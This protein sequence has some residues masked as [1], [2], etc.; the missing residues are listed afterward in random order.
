MMLAHHRGNPP[1]ELAEQI[2]E[3]A[4]A[5]TVRLGLPIF[6]TQHHQAHARA[7]EL[8]RQRSPIRLA[9]S[10][11]ARLRAAPREQSLFEN[12]V[13]QLGRH[14]PSNSARLP[15]ADCPGSCCAPP[16]ACGRSRARS[17]RHGAAATCIVTVAWSALSS[18]A[19]PTSSLMRK[20]WLPE[21][22]TR[23]V[24][25]RPFAPLS[26]GW[27]ASPRNGGRLQFGTVAGIKSESRPAS[28]RN[29]WPECVGICNFPNLRQNGAENTSQK[30]TPSTN[31]K[32]RG[33][34]ATLRWR[35]PDAGLG[36]GGP[37]RL[38]RRD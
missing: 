22:L 15:A 36:A 11:Q 35:L 30:T 2:A 10:A 8:A 37:A 14:R 26:R 3:P 5:V 31:D 20:G 33:K 38:Y 13:G 16:P 23:R 27:P 9:A 21:S 4:V 25:V 32:A 24:V 19:S 1:F 34:S 28:N 18:P 7:L 6:L 29:T 12:V 17:P